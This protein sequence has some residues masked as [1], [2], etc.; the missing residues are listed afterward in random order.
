MDPQYEDAL[1]EGLHEGFVWGCDR[2]QEMPPLEQGR[3]LWAGGGSIVEGPTSE[4]WI[5]EDCFEEFKERFRWSAASLLSRDAFA[6]LAALCSPVRSGQYGPRTIRLVVARL[7]SHL[8]RRL[9][10]QARRITRREANH[11]PSPT[12]TSVA[13]SE[14]TRS[15]QT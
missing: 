2:A 14:T 11:L 3:Q 9:S 12:P 1:H 7:R 13:R 15:S 6:W 5:C 8:Y 4:E 10:T